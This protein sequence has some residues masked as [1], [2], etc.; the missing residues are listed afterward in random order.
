MTTTTQIHENIEELRTLLPEADEDRAFREKHRAKARAHPKGP[1]AY[2]HEKQMY[3][4]AQLRKTDE[5]PENDVH[6]A[7]IHGHRWAV[8]HYIA[9]GMQRSKA[10]LAAKAA[11]APLPK[12]DP[13]AGRLPHW[14]Y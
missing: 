13:R 1:T 5:G 11:K 8:R 7:A 14:G 2:H 6:R 12:E 3:H 10:K 4:T 9:K